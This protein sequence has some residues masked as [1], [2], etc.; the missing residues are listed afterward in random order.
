MA[1]ALKIISTLLS[2]PSKELQE[3]S[4]ELKAAVLD[5]GLTGE[6]AKALLND[7]ID[8]IAKRDV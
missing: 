3:A 4:F 5:D 7:L 1:N 2:Y 8:D 6:P